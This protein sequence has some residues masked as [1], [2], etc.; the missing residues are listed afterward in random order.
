MIFI[1]KYDIIYIEKLKKGRFKM[2]TRGKM[3]K[4]LYQNGIRRT[5]DGKRFIEIKTHEIV[6]L[7]YDTFGGFKN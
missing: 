1:K 5:P 7:Y 4:R 2:L 6:T 3:I